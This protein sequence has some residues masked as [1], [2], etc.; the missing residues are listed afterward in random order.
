[1]QFF[2]IWFMIS[3]SLFGAILLMIYAPLMLIG[4]MGVVLILLIAAALT[5]TI[6][7]D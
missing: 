4:I 5:F 2:A 3:L 6:Y 7:P 1:M